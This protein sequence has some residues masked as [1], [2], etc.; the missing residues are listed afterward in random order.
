MHDLDDLLKG[1]LLDY[2][3]L[4][5]GTLVGV[6][7]V[8]AFF[9]CRGIESVRSKFLERCSN[10]RQRYGQDDRL[11]YQSV[12]CDHG[13]LQRQSVKGE[14]IQTVLVVKGLRNALGMNTG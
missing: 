11:I 13:A 6:P 2:I 9:H 1:L 8:T 7:T 10:K 14:Y 12:N 5:K 3:K 4:A